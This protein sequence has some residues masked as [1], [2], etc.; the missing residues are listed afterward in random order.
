M[1]GASSQNAPS[2]APANF[3][4]A[5]LLKMTIGGLPVELERLCMHTPMGWCPVYEALGMPWELGVRSC[6]LGVR[7]QPFGLGHSC[8]VFFHSVMH[9]CHALRGCHARVSN[10]LLTLCNRPKVVAVGPFLRAR[11]KRGEDDHLCHEP[12]PDVNNCTVTARILFREG[13]RG[14]VWAMHAILPARPETKA[15]I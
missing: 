2:S 10:C 14:T 13:R 11:S 12:V 3:A 8:C 7:F 1:Q 6:Y 4:S 9:S 15:S 5:R